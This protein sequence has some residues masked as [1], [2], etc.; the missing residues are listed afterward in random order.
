MQARFSIE[1]MQFIFGGSWM[2]V[3]QL[4]EFQKL[5]SNSFIVEIVT[6]NNDRRQLKL[7]FDIVTVFQALTST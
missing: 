3:L 4:D 6:W 2:T 5:L 7:L 1:L